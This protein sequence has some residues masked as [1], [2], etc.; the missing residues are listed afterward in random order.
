MTDLGVDMSVVG[1]WMDGQGLLG[2]GDPIALPAREPAQATVAAIAPPKSTTFR[3]R[4]RPIHSDRRETA[5]R[6]SKHNRRSKAAM[7]FSGV[8]DRPT[9][10]NADR[11]PARWDQRLIAR[12]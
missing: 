12:R 11:T 8:S 1:A 6:R 5:T 4:I 3:K 7:E 9:Y 10:Y 2:A